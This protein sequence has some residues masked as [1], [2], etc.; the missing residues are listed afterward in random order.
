MKIN[1]KSKGLILCV[2]DNIEICRIAVD[3]FVA[4]KYDV[5]PALSA[6]EG[7]DIIKKHHI[8]MLLLDMR[9]EGMGGKGLL[10]KLSDEKI[11]IPTLVITA[12]PQNIAEKHSEKFKICGYFEKPVSWQQVYTVIEK[13]T[14]TSNPYNAFFNKRIF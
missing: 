1:N 11:N 5:I 2:D 7:Y 10:K 12:Y 4:R 9:M 3:F 8:D 13:H 6:E 14:S